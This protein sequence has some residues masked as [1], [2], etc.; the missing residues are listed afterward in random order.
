MIMLKLCSNGR[1]LHVGMDLIQK[2]NSHHI[3]NC[4]LT[5]IVFKQNFTSGF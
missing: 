1:N 4:I 5:Q 2:K 3:P